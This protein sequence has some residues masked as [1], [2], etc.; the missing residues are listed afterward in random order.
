LGVRKTV[1]FAILTAVRLASLSWPLSGVSGRARKSISAKEIREYSERQVCD[2]RHFSP[3]SATINTNPLVDLSGVS[4]T[5]RRRSKSQQSKG[6][7]SASPL[8][9]FCFS[10]KEKP[11]AGAL[12]LDVKD[13]ARKTVLSISFREG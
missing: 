13:E 8:G 5:P 11:S 3:P 6:P 9:V 2:D 7:L 4:P 12:T 10:D 1:S